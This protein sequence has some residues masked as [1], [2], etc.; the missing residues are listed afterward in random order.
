MLVKYLAPFYTEGMPTGKSNPSPSTKKNSK[1]SKLIKGVTKLELGC[2]N[3]K[4]KGFFG[5]DILPSPVVDLVLDIE[6]HKLPFADSSIDHIYTSHTFEHLT[7]YR[8][9]LQEIMRVAKPNALVE[10]WTPY[11]KSNDGM[12]FG[13]F[14]FLS[15]TS[16]KHICFEYDRFYLEE[17][18]GYLLWEKSHYNLFPGIVEQ[19]KA[20][21]IPLDFALDHL[22]NIALE[23]GV[24]L[25]VKKSPR[26][27]K[28]PGPQYP[29]SVFYYGG[30]KERI[31]TNHP[32]DVD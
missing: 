30:R 21:K 27:K 25:R 19:L 31:K 28:A 18:E 9:V 12:L 1:R 7:E 11:G 13:H 23:W 29:K 16:F 14:T 15:E 26:Y 6:T 10:I 2:G 17:I 8:F 5:I 4:R 20:M 22:F 24:F 32:A 3:V